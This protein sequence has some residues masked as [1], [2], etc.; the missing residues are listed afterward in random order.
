MVLWVREAV[1]CFKHCLM[2]HITRNM[3]GMNCGGLAK[4]VILKKINMWPR[5]HFYDILVKNVA[6]FCPCLKSLPEAKV[7]RFGLIPLAEKII[8]KQSSIN[9]VLWLLV[10]TL[11]KIYNGKE[12]AEQGKLQYVQFEEKSGT[13]K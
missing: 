3:E 10:I 9:S 4:E 7:K 6:A 13:K 1:E 2:G 5:D 12:Q 11:L 8:S